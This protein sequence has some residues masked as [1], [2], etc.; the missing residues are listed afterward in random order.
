MAI[1]P[2][3]PI[4]APAV[5][6]STCSHV[7]QMATDAIYN[8]TH[9]DIAKKLGKAR[10]T[11]TETLRLAD[12][13]EEIQAACEK[14]GI[15]QRGILLEV[16]KQP[17]PEAMAQAIKSHHTLGLKREDLRKERKPKTRGRPQ[18]Y[19]YRHTLQNK[20]RLELKFTKSKATRSDIIQALRAI[21][22]DLESG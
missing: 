4:P 6:G 18:N 19:V 15:T 7:I 21:L 2:T 16:A 10:T 1:C 11:I 13:P 12:L 8:Y 3:W 14:A 20:A 17:N 5:Q 9:Q 22:A